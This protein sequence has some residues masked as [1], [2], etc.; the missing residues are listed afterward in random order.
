[1]RPGHC[2]PEKVHPVSARSIPR[3]CFNEAG[4]L[5]PGK[6]SGVGRWNTAAIWG[7]NEAGALC[8]G[9]GSAAAAA[10]AVAPELQ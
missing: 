3:A 4:A 1:M 7:F 9:K 8:P 6:G 2:A 5:C 10:V